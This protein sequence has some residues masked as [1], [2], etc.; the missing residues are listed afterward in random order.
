MNLLQR[1][2][3]ALFT[4]V[5]LSG[6]W[7]TTHSQMAAASSLS[8]HTLGIQSDAQT[9]YPG[10]G[11]LRLAYT[12]CGNSKLSGQVL[13]QTISAY[14]LKGIQI[15]LDICQPKLSVILNKTYLQ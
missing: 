6:M 10:I 14:H 11:W 7:L 2:L 8:T 5:L 12:T 4:I 13:Q 3:F 1:K 9:P 15:L